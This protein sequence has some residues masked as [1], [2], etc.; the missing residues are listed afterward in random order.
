MGK[1]AKYP[2]QLYIVQLADA[3]HTILT[4]L[5]T[6]ML[7]D[8]LNTRPAVE[9][10]QQHEGIWRAREAGDPAGTAYTRVRVFRNP[11]R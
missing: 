8:E 6:P 11:N 4:G 1:H 10:W 5:P 3:P 7:L 2:D 9:A